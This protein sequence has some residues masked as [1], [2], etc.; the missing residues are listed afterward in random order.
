MPRGR[1]F[2][3]QRGGGSGGVAPEGRYV[4]EGARFQLR[5]QG[6]GGC[7]ARWAWL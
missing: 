6:I 3:T 2:Q 7:D 4:L 1:S 5:V